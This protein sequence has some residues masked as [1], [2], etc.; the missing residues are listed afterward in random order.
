MKS[1][2]ELDP[3]LQSLYWNCEHGEHNIAIN[4]LLQLQLDAYNQGSNETLQKIKDANQ[5]QQQA[6]QHLYNL[7]E[8]LEQQT[9]INANPFPFPH[10][11]TYTA[12]GNPCKICG[13]YYKFKNNEQ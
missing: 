8:E 7:I 11:C 1:K 10:T 4:K 5:P 6:K 2:E 9:D 12:D 3:L 13:E